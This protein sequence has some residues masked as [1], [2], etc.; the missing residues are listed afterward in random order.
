[1]QCEVCDDGAAAAPTASPAPAAASEAAPAPPPAL[2]PLRHKLQAALARVRMLTSMQ[3]SKIQRTNEYFDRPENTASPE[4]D[5]WRRD[6][7]AYP[8]LRNDVGG[9][10]FGSMIMDAESVAER[11][12]AA[13]RD[14]GGVDLA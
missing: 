10:H 3:V 2:E 14:A 4:A 1:M 9:W 11:A 5:A 7:L 8:M 13:F 12:Q 6:L